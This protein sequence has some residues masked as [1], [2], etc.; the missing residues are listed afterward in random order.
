LDAVTRAMPVPAD[1]A[2]RTTCP[3]CGVGCGVTVLQPDSASCRVT[4]DV[5]HPANAG[6]LCS[7][8]AA[9][10]ATLGTT[11]RL[12]RPRIGAREPDWDEALDTVAARLAATIAEHGR[13]AVAVYGSGQLLTEDYYAANK[14]VKGWLGTANIDTNS[15]LCMASSVAG[16]KRAFGTD[17]VPGRYADLEQADLVILVG[18]NLAWCHPVLHQRLLAARE[19]RPTLRILVID[20]RA[21]ATTAMADRHLAIEPDR[22]ADLFGGLLAHLARHD[23]LDNDWMAAHVGGAKAS[24]AAVAPLTRAETIRRTGLSADDIACLFDAFRTT[25]RVV[26]VYSQG[27]NQGARG[28]DTVNAIINC[29][30]ATNRIGRAGTGPFSVT[31]QPNAMGGR[32]VGGLSN[33]LAAHTELDDAGARERVQRF[34]DSPHIASTPGPKAIELFERIA[35]G[36]I[37]AVWILATNPVDSLPDADRV[38][39]ALAAC[40]FV[41]VSDVVPDTDTARLAHVLLPSAAWGEKDG[42]VTNSERCISRQRGFRP[43]PGAARPDWW[44][45]AAVA[46]RLGAHHGF[47]WRGPADIFREHAALSAVAGSPDF[48]IG[49]AAALSDADYR[50]LRPFTWPWRQGSDP[51]SDPERDPESAPAASRF[52]GDGR[53]HTGD[54]RARMIPIVPAPAGSAPQDDRAFVLNTGR[55][56]DQW[57]TMTRTGTVPALSSH[58]GEPFV[59][60]APTDA[61]RL[62]IG[63]ADI[64]ELTSAHGRVQARALVTDRQR[65]GSLF[66]PMHWSE[67]FASRA[68]VDALVSPV[69]D[70]VSGQPASKSERV[71][72]ARWP[73]RAFGY[74]L[75]RE[76]PVRLPDRRRH[77]WALAPVPGG[78]Q[79]ELAGL[80]GAEALE[81][82]C[83][84][85][86]QDNER[87]PDGPPSGPARWLEQS[88]PALGGSRRM[89]VR[90]GRL[91]GAACVASAPVS[92]ARRWLIERLGASLEDGVRGDGMSVLAGRPGGAVRDPGATVCVCHSVG[93]NTIR[94]AIGSGR[95]RS[96]AELGTTLQAGANCGACRPELEALLRS[97]RDPYSMNPCSRAIV[98]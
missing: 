70:P 88:D 31:G 15:R 75:L 82:T 53:F 20:P 45:I 81:A 44:Q 21:T 54:G 79:L 43:L 3:Y 46:R 58:L 32:E 74:V 41:V 5:A 59:E 49:A 51:G 27:V 26:T 35:E 76:R 10:A 6:R 72:L 23:A 24:L 38:R 87:V 25:E 33:M 90:D 96:V 48:D 98:R 97:A 77:Y 19:A 14:F 1:D 57:H 40:P 92:V 37:R 42:T 18:S 29:H 65:T 80:D 52:F 93:A 67:V 66:M 89:L 50:A 7:K 11:G 64:V 28:T 9:L 91:R 78:W 8:G 94:D 61:A 2:V 36:R 71:S 73:A 13:D 22:D 69:L 12:L 95:C 85:L 4:G 84:R 55:T 34:W 62:G 86:L 16:H 30:L 60:I 17:T 63:A 47:D 68:R 39:A 56:R 83:R